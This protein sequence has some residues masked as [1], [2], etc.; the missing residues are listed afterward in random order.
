MV[1]FDSS[2]LVKGYLLEKGSAGVVALCASP[3]ARYT[4]TLAY[5]EVVA[6]FARKFRERMISADE[7]ARALGDFQRDWTI[8]FTEVA[9]DHSILSAL[10]LLFQTHPLKGSDGVHLASAML[11]QPTAQALGDRLLFCATDERLLRA[12]ET[13]GLAVMNPESA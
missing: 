8:S 3:E 13:S 5:A 9:L 10:P 7:W 1:Y 6:A 4:S 11:L 12:A 2:A